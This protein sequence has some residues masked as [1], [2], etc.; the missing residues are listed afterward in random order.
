M[1]DIVTLI[2]GCV[3]LAYVIASVLIMEQFKRRAL[4]TKGVVR[5]DFRRTVRRFTILTLLAWMTLSVMFLVVY[6]VADEPGSASF[7]SGVLF[8]LFGFLVYAA[9]LMIGYFVLL[10]GVFRLPVLDN[11]GRD[12]VSTDSG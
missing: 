10:R 7:S 6:L 5:G 11:D 3:I 2:L 12:E 8:C 4:Q 1:Q 9:L